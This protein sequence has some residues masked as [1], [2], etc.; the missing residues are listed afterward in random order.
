MRDLYRRSG[1]AYVSKGQLCLAHPPDP[2]L[3]SS[4]FSYDFV[5]LIFSGE[6]RLV[7]ALDSV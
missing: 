6:A 2:S 3:G 5:Y 7:C 4:A 1:H